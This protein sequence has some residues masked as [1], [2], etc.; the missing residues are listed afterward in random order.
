MIIIRRNDG[1]QRLAGIGW[2]AATTGQPRWLPLSALAA[3]CRP[4]WLPLMES[5][6]GHNPALEWRGKSAKPH[7]ICTETVRIPY[8]FRTVWQGFRTVSVWFPMAGCHRSLIQPYLWLVVTYLTP[9]G[10]RRFYGRDLVGQP[11]R[12]SAS[13][14]RQLPAAASGWPVVAASQPTQPASQPVIT[15]YNYD[16]IV[17]NPAKMLK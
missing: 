3:T 6:E 11:A 7:G 5:Q 12:A 9:K 2:L 10:S 15:S 4:R 14:Q 13:D 1:Q 8:G 17:L 16:N